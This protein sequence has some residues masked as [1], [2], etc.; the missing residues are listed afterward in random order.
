MARKAKPARRSPNTGA[1]RHRP[2]RALPYEAAFKHADG[3]TQYDY[4]A[5]AEEAAAHLDGLIAARDD[6]HA[7]RN[8]AKGAQTVT[9]QKVPNILA[10]D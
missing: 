10:K 1:I 9:H 5:T 7:P 8:I 3:T 2:G 4:F 6:A